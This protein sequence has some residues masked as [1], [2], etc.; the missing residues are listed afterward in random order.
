MGYRDGRRVESLLSGG[1]V[2]PEETRIRCPFCE[3][4][5]HFDRKWSLGANMRTG[6]WQCFR[7]GKKGRLPGFQTEDEEEEW[8]P[9]FIAPTKFDLPREYVR[10]YETDNWNSYTFEDARSYLEGRHVTRELAEELQ[11]GACDEGFWGGRIIIPHH[12]PGKARWQGW[13]AR[14]YGPP[15]S[16][17]LGSLPYL[18]PR[19]MQ[20]GE[21][22]YNHAAVL[23]DTD[24]PLIVTE[25]PFKCFPY[26]PHAVGSFGKP[27]KAQI[28]SLKLATRPIAIVLD[29]DAWEL[30]WM[31]SEQLRFAGKYAGHVR[32]PPKTDPDQVD[33]RWLIKQVA[34]CIRDPAV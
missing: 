11:I 22:F 33:P 5:G 1:K 21:W 30:G 23:E 27:T 20:R 29:G 15:A 34:G 26:H 24:I 17:G 3:D 8:T 18:Y 19:G 12:V 14:L 2:G 31:I 6:W 13:A 16:E 4:E 25:A 9:N 7:C 28:A 32:L 10:I